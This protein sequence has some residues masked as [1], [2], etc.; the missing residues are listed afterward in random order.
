MINVD[1]G[2]ARMSGSVEVILAE[3]CVATRALKL[4]MAREYE[5]P[6]E[7]VDLMVLHTIEETLAEDMDGDEV[8]HMERLVNKEGGIL[9]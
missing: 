1:K 7:L 3:I 9:R 8:F 5:M 4:G 6:E 2:E